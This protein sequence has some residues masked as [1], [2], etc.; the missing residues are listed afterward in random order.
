LRTAKPAGAAKP[1]PSS[2]HDSG[3]FCFFATR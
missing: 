1:T 3:A 2:F